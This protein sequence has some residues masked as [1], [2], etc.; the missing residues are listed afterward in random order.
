[1]AIRTIKKD[2]KTV[3]LY[4]AFNTQAHAHDIEFRRTK[5]SN[6]LYDAVV[7]GDGSMTEKEVDEAEKVLDDLT[8]ILSMIDFP[9]TYLPYRL[10]VVAKET[11]LWADCARHH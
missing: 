10:Y 7:F 4:P 9:I 6:Q 1:M 8:E 11:I 2:G 5:I 3:K